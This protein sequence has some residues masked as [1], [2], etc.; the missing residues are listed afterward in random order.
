MLKRFIILCAPRT[1][2]NLLTAAL[3]VHPAVVMYSEIFAPEESFRQ[4]QSA[5]GTPERF[6]PAEYFRAAADPAAFL[7]QQ[8]YGAAFPPQKQA[9][10]FKLFH[11]H[12]RSGSAARLW[13]W[14]SAE[15]DVHVIQLYRQRLL[16]SYLSF[17]IASKT[18]QWLVPVSAGAHAAQVAP[19]TIDVH[20]FKQYADQQLEDRRRAEELFRDHP[21]LTI[22][23]LDDVCG[24]FDATISKI[25]AFLGIASLPLPI[26]LKKQAQLPVSE[27]ITD[28]DRIYDALA[29]TKYEAFL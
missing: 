23:Y 6:G 2:S 3:H 9:V 14:L 27:E 5:M 21:R 4:M 7:E 8:V 1:G 17:L 29:G 13:D 20:Q 15:K 11:A 28:F 10:G 12:M 18:R 26:R 24:R 16:E 25:E 19:V 22:E